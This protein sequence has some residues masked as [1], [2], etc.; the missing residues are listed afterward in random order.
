M[1]IRDMIKFQVVFADILRNDF[2][3]YHGHF[4][5]P[6]TLRFFR[7]RI[8]EI[9]YRHPDGSVYFLTSEKKC[10]NDP[11]RVWSVRRISRSEDGIKIDTL[12]SSG[13]FPNKNSAFSHLRE[14][15][16]GVK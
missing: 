15:F 9:G 6:D 4:F 16:G 8:S 3:D 13:A 12:P 2:R 11:T 14:I 10:F 1:K 5:S 7:S